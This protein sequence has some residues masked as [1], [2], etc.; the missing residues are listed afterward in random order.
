MEA[1]AAN[2]RK[3][4]A[5]GALTQDAARRMLRTGDDGERVVASAAMQGNPDLTD[6]D[7]VLDAIGRSHS[8]FEQY[9][10]LLALDSARDR[11]TADQQRAA[12]EVILQQQQDQHGFLKPDNADRFALS[13]QLLAQLKA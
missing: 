8:A 9:H 4:G 1:I 13:N 10:A 6:V 2:A 3:L 11:L 7:G 12:R 5:A